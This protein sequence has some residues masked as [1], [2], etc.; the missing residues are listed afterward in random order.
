MT[1]DVAFR[2][3][4]IDELLATLGALDE[5]GMRA[6]ATKSMKR[7]TK[8]LETAI[9]RAAPVGTGHRRSS[10][11]GKKGKRGPLARN[12]TTRSIRRRQGELVALQ[13]GPRAWYKHFVIR[14]TRR[15]VIEAYDAQGGRAERSNLAEVRAAQ[16]AGIRPPKRTYDAVSAINRL[17]AGNL[18]AWGT[19]GHARA[20]RFN[21]RY[22][23]RVRHPGARGNDFVVR[24]ARGKATEIR[25][26]L[27][28]DIETRI[29][30]ARA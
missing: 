29:E 20:L 4:G 28:A 1:E 13:V 17:E 30:A 5:K 14:G 7:S 16:K 24:A 25:D 18:P 10:Q 12:V 19:D 2:V 21:R 8:G 26:A 23:F 15:H 27:A 22:V 3:T 9:K 6:L 11:V